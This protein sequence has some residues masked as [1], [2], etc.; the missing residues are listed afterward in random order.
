MNRSKKVRHI[1]AE[2]VNTLGHTMSKHELLECASLIVSAYEDPIR[3][4]AF[5]SEGRTPL[6]ELPVNHVIEQ[7]S[8]ELVSD[9]YLTMSELNGAPADDYLS[10]VS[11]E[12]QWQQLL[13]A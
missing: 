9:D 11:Q 2:L 13:A 7:W 1:F 10:H 4:S 12:Y 3:Q 6:C 8:W 5:L